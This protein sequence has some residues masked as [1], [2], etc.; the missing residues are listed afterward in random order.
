MKPLHLEI[1]ACLE[2]LLYLFV[3]F[4]LK[5]ILDKFGSLLR[6][7]AMIAFYP[8]LWGQ[9]LLRVI[10]MGLRELSQLNYIFSQNFAIRWNLNNRTFVAGVQR[11]YDGK[12]LNPF[13]EYNFATIEGVSNSDSF[14]VI[15]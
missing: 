9:Q 10:I 6:A 2:K 15:H 1:V 11:E 7:N 4:V 3:I 12:V 5:R 8:N 14:C 13:I